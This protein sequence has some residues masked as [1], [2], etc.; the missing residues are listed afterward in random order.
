[1]NVKN[2]YIG[3]ILLQEAL[4]LLK[5]FQEELL[6]RHTENHHLN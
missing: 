2:F 4:F 1:M 5:T 3:S 6:T